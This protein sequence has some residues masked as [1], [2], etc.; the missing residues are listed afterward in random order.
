MATG[1]LLSIDSPLGQVLMGLYLVCVNEKGTVVE[2][3][4]YLTSGNLRY[5]H[6][7]VAKIYRWRFAPYLV[8]GGPVGV[9]A[10]ERVRSE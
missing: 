4:T 7:V 1:D 3:Y 8:D 2:V 6:D 5:D 10:F 9:C